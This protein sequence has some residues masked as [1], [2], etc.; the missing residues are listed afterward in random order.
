MSTHDNTPELGRIGLW[1]G[2]KIDPGFAAEIE[3]LGYGALWVGGSPAADLTDIE[4]LLDATDAIPVATGIVNVWQADAVTVAASYHRIEAR[5]PGRFLLGIGIGHPE[6][7]QEFAKPY[8]TLVD[9]LDVLDAHEVPVER[10]VLAALGPK[11]MKLSAERS[12][13]AH[14]YLTTPEHTRQ[15]R[16]ILG[17]GRLLVPD[18]KIVLETDRARAREIGDGV[19]ARY[20]GLQNYVANLRRL[21]FT[22]EDFADGG[23]DR[24]FDAVILNGDLATIVAGVQAHLD[25]GADQVAVQV[26]GDGEGDL[27]PA[28]RALAEAF[29]L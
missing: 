4:R 5:H 13:G 9:Y 19:L 1:R 24:L 18:Q 12:A 22:D 28:Y 6:A 7:T 2:G 26:I 14:P 21:G 17:T 15:A 11:V 23:S 27:L 16:E 29:S 10:R 20:L 25:A 8:A 3:Q